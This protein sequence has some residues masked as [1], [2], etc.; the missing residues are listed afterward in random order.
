MKQLK[1]IF[2]K[3]FFHQFGCFSVKLAEIL[4]LSKRHCLVTNKWLL[5]PFLLLRRRFRKETSETGP[6]KIEYQKFKTSHGSLFSLY[7]ILYLNNHSLLSSF[8]FFISFFNYHW[9][10][11]ILIVCLDLK[12][13]VWPIWLNGWVFVYELIRCGFESR[14]SHLISLF[15]IYPIKLISCSFTRFI[16]I[17][18]WSL[19]WTKYLFLFI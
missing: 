19:Y 5:T 7:H 9:E 12:G 3:F 15:Y 4:T 10:M 11:A 18:L 17:F 14:C 13:L 2:L 1:V 8:S 16:H 6:H